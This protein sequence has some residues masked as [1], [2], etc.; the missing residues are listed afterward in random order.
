[1]LRLLGQRPDIVKFEG[2]VSANLSNGTVNDIWESIWLNDLTADLPSG[3]TQDS[4]SWEQTRIRPS[5][6]VMRATLHRTRG[7]AGRPR[8]TRLS[9]KPNSSIKPRILPPN[10]RRGSTTAT[11]VTSYRIRSPVDI[12]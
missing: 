7:T 4:L 12:S 10:M 9:G 8:T 11:P 5:S 1:M 2:A 3:L 6:P